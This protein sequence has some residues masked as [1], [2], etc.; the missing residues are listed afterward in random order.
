MK[1]VEDALP[2]GELQRIVDGIASR[3]IDPY[4]AAAAIM[5][6]VGLVVPSHPRTPAPSDAPAHP[7]TVGLSHSR[8]DVE[9]SKP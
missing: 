8:S 3:A 7:R 4:S 5:A 1:T 2:A 6:R 9:P